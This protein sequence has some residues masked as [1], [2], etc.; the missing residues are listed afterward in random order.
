MLTRDDLIDIV[1]AA[2]RPREPAR[3][4]APAPA[5]SPRGKGAPRP[6]PAG[7]TF[8]TEHEIRRR[9]TPDGKRLTIAGNPILSPLALD[10]LALKGIEIVR[11][12]S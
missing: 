4:A 3:P 6:G 9:L 10:W 12:P 8:L 7:R 11:E 2:L 1:L 5:A